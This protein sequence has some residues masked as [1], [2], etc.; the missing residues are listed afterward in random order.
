MTLQAGPKQVIER[1]ITLVANVDTDDD[2]LF[3]YGDN[4]PGV[5][6]PNQ[7]D[8]DSDGIGDACDL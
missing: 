4:C 1:E 2:G 7:E 8:E 5:S 3:D 6:N